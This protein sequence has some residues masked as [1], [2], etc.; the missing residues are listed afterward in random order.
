MSGEN[1]K[2]L[3]LYVEVYDKLLKLIGEG[4]YP[5]G[6]KLPAESKL[7]KLMNVSRMTLRQALS[8][9]QEDGYIETIH[10]QGN[11][12]KNYVNFKKIG[13]EKIDNTV[14][15]CCTEDIDDIDAY[16]RVNFVDDYDYV[17]NIFNRDSAIIIGFN[18]WYK[19]K[20][21]LVAYTFSMFPSETAS[22]Y[23]INL[24]DEQGLLKI[25]EDDIY[26]LVH[27][28]TIE[29]KFTTSVPP[30]LHYELHSNNNLF[31]LLIES[32]YDSMGNVILQNKIYIPTELSSIKI[33]RIN[34]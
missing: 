5:I 8:L 27:S 31:T 1:N 11:F 34:K 3:P 32:L 19:C 21:K 9:L 16:F 12:I 25:L 24:N 23:Q 26:K 6:S 33:N 18:R 29:I 17:K 22:Q 7:S 15:Q 4:V 28:S 14:T 30:S 10:G 2:K 20:N 13:L